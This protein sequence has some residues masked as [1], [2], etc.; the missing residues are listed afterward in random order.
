MTSELCQVCENTGKDLVGERG[1]PGDLNLRLSRSWPVR[2]WK[3]VGGG[4]TW[5]EEPNRSKGLEVW[6]LGTCCRG[7]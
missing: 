4:P 6:S 1:I 7:R 3:E 2:G 5:A